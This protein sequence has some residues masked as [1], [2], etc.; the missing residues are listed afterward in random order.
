V[1]DAADSKRVILSWHSGEVRRIGDEFVLEREGQRSVFAS[2]TQLLDSLGD[3]VWA[4]GETSAWD[5]MEVVA[6]G[7]ILT[8]ADELGIDDLFPFSAGGWVKLNGVWL[9][10][11]GIPDRDGEPSSV[12]T[13]V[14]SFGEY[15]VSADLYEFEGAYCCSWSGPEYE[16][17]GF[18]V[19]GRISEREAIERA[20]DRAWEE[21]REWDLLF[22]KSGGLANLR[23][24]VALP[25]Q[26]V[27]LQ[28]RTTYLD[29]GD[30]VVDVD[31]HRSPD[32]TIWVTDHNS[33]DAMGH[34][35]S[36]TA[37][38]TAWT[39]GDYHEVRLE[40]Y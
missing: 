26:S 36:L 11:A 15:G 22:D 8:A 33:L 25:S 34:F 1:N 21:M 35:D 38:D 29:T 16:T 28:R 19:Y 12:F 6:V 39:G 4:I 3:L 23:E 18:E 17:H 5:G 37:I 31:I 13:L 2:L 24:A 9:P 14:C 30:I 7:E 27:M 40:D 32:G 20:S 10:E